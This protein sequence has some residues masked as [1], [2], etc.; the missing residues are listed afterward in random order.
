MPSWLF[1][2]TNPPLFLCCNYG[3]A[4]FAATSYCAT[5]VLPVCDTTR[6]DKE[7][8][9]GT[10]PYANKT[11]FLITPIKAHAQQFVQ[12]SN[13]DA[14]VPEFPGKPALV[15]MSITPVGTGK[16]GTVRTW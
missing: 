10:P 11:I 3:V 8:N 6:D 1:I 4:I 13:D 5:T 15:L 14:T 12:V 7:A 2:E 9:I 16:R